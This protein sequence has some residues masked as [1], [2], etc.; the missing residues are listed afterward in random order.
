MIKAAATTKDGRIM[1]VFGLSR[2][3]CERLLKGKPI[4]FDC[5]EF[6]VDA[7]VL[8]MGGDT[9]QAI[10]DEIK[11]AGVVLPKEA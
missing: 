6:G 11:A 10:V 2:L 4:Q 7:E 3:N 9:E 1:L 8:I 5:R